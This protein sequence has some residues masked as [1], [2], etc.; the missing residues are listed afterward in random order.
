MMLRVHQGPKKTVIRLPKRFDTD[1]LSAFSM[2]VRRA[3]VTPE[4]VLDFGETVSVDS[5]ALDVLR[6]FGRK[7]DARRGV[8]TLVNCRPQIRRMLKRLRVA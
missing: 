7:L 8:F 5:S 1:S 6:E 2:S 4:Y 3:S